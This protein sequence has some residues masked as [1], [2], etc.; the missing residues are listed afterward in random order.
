MSKPSCKVG[1]MNAE[2]E[3]K[4]QIL[5]TFDITAHA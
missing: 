3:L 5:M 2:A 1:T 4:C